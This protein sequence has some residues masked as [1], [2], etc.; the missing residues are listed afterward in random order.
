MNFYVTLLICFFAISSNCSIQYIS[1][2][3]FCHYDDP[4]VPEAIQKKTYGILAPLFSE[5]SPLFSEYYRGQN[6]IVPSQKDFDDR[7][8]DT[9]IQALKYFL[10]VLGNTYNL[11]QQL[12]YHIMDY[13]SPRIQSDSFKY[14]R[15]YSSHYHN[16]LFSIPCLNKDEIL[17]LHDG[18]GILEFK[19]EKTKILLDA[20]M[21]FNCKSP[22]AILKI[23]VTEKL[24]QRKLNSDNLVLCLFEFGYIAV[25]DL[26]LKRKVFEFDWKP[27]LYGRL[28]G[29]YKNIICAANKKALEFHNFDEIFSCKE[30]LY[31]I[32]DEKFRD[33]KFCKIHD[34][35]Y[36]V[37]STLNLN[38]FFYTFCFYQSGTQYFKAIPPRSSFKIGG[39]DFRHLYYMSYTDKKNEEKILFALNDINN[40]FVWIHCNDTCLIAR[41]NTRRLYVFDITKEPFNLK[42]TIH[43]SEECLHKFWLDC[44]SEKILTE[45][46]TF[47][48][49]DFFA[50]LP[51]LS[52]SENGLQS[53]QVE[54]NFYTGILMRMYWFVHSW[55]WFFKF[56]QKAVILF[57]KKAFL[58]KFWI[59]SI[60]LF[61]LSFLKDFF[62][63]RRSYFD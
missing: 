41:D 59:K 2:K 17:L 43:D 30:T 63:I 3:Q 15:E 7:S 32:S 19:N 55:Y 5:Y 11:E 53:S 37:S 46:G 22:T 4:R 58:N 28:I 10:L 24:I 18:Y 47:K 61:S 38:F 62:K 36:I 31:T 40:F 23:P 14:I 33:K 27:S 48:I 54:C 8:L 29:G 13:I 50:G 21:G 57:M 6:A 26:T 56:I 44:D 60:A 39:D 1:F 12:V 16:N 34:E 35:K 9:R 20:P 51:H 25:V 52:R 45:K 49:Q 42:F